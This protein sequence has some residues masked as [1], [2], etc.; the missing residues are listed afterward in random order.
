MEEKNKKQ[1][2]RF[3][4]TELATIR[5]VF[6]N[7]D[8]LLKALRKLFLQIPLDVMDLSI[9]ELMKKPDVLKIVRKLFLPEI[10]PEAPIN[11]IIDLW[12]T[13]DARGKSPEELVPHFE[14]RERVIKYLDQQLKV[15][16]GNGK[17]KIRFSKLGYSHRKSAYNNYVDFEVRNTILVHVETQLNQ[18]DILSLPEETREEMEKRTKMNSAK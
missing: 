5:S 13:I 3:S 10:D 12:M 11:Q 6:G 14:A 2:M 9:V 4:E 18:L 17:E 7:N 1:V 8:E 16:E 15:L